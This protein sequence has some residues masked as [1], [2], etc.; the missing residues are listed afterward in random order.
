MLRDVSDKYRFLGRTV[1]G[2][3]RDE[4]LVRDEHLAILTAIA[5]GRSD[6]AERFVRAHITATREVIE[7][8]LE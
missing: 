1:I 4:K 2:T 8:V 7:R 6:D 5:D 3:E